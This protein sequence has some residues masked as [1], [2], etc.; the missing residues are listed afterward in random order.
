MKTTGGFRRISFRSVSVRGFDD[1]GKPRTGPADPSLAGHAT[2]R[3]LRR[4][5]FVALSGVLLLVGFGIAIGV[6]AGNNDELLATG[7]RTDGV[8]VAYH[9]R[10]KIPDLIDVQFLRGSQQELAEISLN[11]SSPRYRVGD[12]VTVI[13]DPADPS[14]VRTDAEE[15]DPG[16]F[17]LPVI[18]ALILGLIMMPGG[19][20]G[21]GRWAR[22]IKQARTAEWRPAKAGL[23][24]GG[25]GS[26]TRLRV[27]FDDGVE[28]VF[29]T[30]RPVQLPLPREIFTGT[31]RV[32]LNGTGHAV[33]VM[34]EH[35]PFLVAAKRAGE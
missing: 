25:W 32:W 2:G 22:R 15:N 26:K 4:S 12:Q 7:A 24:K 21:L 1:I 10:I 34:F 5:L 33:T 23:V 31:Q 28:Q 14:R 18:I 17:L 27:R 19:L 29:V 11:D 8:V 20:I 16:I 30:A 9:D 13:Y 35:G 6:N 3:L